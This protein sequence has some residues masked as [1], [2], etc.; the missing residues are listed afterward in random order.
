MKSLG[1]GGAIMIVTAEVL[2]V[3]DFWYCR[4]GRG[5][6]RASVRSYLATCSIK[7]RDILV[8]AYLF[9]RLFVRR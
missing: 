6:V 1:G 7:L 8:S 5:C 9:A 4:S 3:G 2:N